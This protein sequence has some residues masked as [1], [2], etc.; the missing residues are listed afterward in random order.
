MRISSSLAFPSP[1]SALLDHAEWWTHGQHSLKTSTVYRI[2]FKPCYLLALAPIFWQFNHK[3]SIVLTRPLHMFAMLEA[4]CQLDLT[5]T[6]HLTSSK[7]RKR[8]FAVTQTRHD[9]WLAHD[10]E[11]P[12]PPPS[13]RRDPFALLR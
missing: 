5:Q 2:V 7:R 1:A 9:S 10:R 6:A 12:A 8:R 3:E 4:R 11:R 13:P